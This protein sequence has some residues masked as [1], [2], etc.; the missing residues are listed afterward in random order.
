MRRREAALPYE[1][2]EHDDAPP[3]RLVRFRPAEWRDEDEV[4]PAYRA[5]DKEW[6]D[7]RYLRAAQRWREA[8]HEWEEDHGFKIQAWKEW[9]MRR[10]A[11]TERPEIPDW[12]LRP[13]GQDERQQAQEWALANGYTVLQLLI[14]E[15]AAG[16]A[17]RGHD[18]SRGPRNG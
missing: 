1:D 3:Q 7:W 6:P 9:Q 10:R 4:P 12:A 17:D 15:S 16:R 5:E 13:R 2:P 14:A 11:D 8:R 18:E